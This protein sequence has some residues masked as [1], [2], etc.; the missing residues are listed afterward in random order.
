MTVGTI[1]QEW[2]IF[3]DMVVPKDAGEAQIADMRNAFYAGAGMM[4]A[5]VKEATDLP[6]ED[7]ACAVLESLTEECVSFGVQMMIGS[8]Q[9]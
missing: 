1:Q 3:R 6:N 4:F 8:I 9:Q 5:L 2:E 7:A